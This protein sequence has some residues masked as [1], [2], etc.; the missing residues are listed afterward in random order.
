MTTTETQDQTQISGVLRALGAGET[1]TMT[2]IPTPGMIRA[3]RRE[4]TVS[5]YRAWIMSITLAALA[6]VLTP[7]P[8]WVLMGV[9]LVLVWWMLRDTPTAGTCE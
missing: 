9:W 3:M 2:P 8:I 1:V 7:W 4:Y 6:V 5:L